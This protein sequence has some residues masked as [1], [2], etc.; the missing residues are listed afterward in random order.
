[1]HGDRGLTVTHRRPRHHR[2]GGLGLG[3]RVEIPRRGERPLDQPA[4]VARRSEQRRAAVVVEDD[5]VRRRRRIGVE[6]LEVRRR[7]LPPAEGDEDARVSVGA[8]AVGEVER[9]QG[10][11]ADP[12]RRDVLAARRAVAAD[13]HRSPPGQH[14]RRG[15][16]AGRRAPA[17]PDPA[18]GRTDPVEVARRRR[19]CVDPL[20]DEVAQVDGHRSSPSMVAPALRRFARAADACDFT[21][22]REQPS[23]DA[24]CSSLRSS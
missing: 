20:L 17:A 3:G 9:A 12:V 1:M 10:R 23:A 7:D 11:V 18:T 15:S 19:H 16:R 22:P 2:L 21:V 8:D 14:Q 24:I 4:V 13:H 6:P 5:A